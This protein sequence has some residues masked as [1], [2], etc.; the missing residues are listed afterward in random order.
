MCGPLLLLL[1]GVPALE[2]FG[3]MRVAERIG[4]LETLLLV[5][6]GFMLGVGLMR[7]QSAA[8]LRN[9]QSGTPPTA[10]MLAGPLVFVAALLLMF[11]GF[12]TD[13]LALPLLLPPVRRALARRLVARSLGAR[14][15]AQGGRGGFVFT[16]GGMR[17][18]S[19][20]RDPGAPEDVDAT[21]SVRGR[22]ERRPDDWEHPTG[23]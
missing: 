19:P 23:G 5:V 21:P 13:A 10:D 4:G 16:A 20:R 11:P 18:A 22:I 3:L 1:I 2:I 15:Q 6:G 9:L 8:A 12:V 17:S 14:F 7:G